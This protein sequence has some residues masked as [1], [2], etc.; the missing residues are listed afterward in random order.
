M[1]TK[2]ITQI[3]GRFMKKFYFVLLFIMAISFAGNAQTE[4]TEKTANDQPI[5]N[6]VEYFMGIN[7]GIDFNTNA[8]PLFKNGNYGYTYFGVSP[9]YNIGADFAVKITARLRPRLEFKYVNVKYGVDWSTLQYTFGEST[10]VNLNYFDIN[11]HLDYLLLSVRKFQLFVSPAFKFEAQTGYSLSTSKLYLELKQPSSIA[12]GG[13][14]A[15]FKYK[16]TKHI[17]FTLTPDYTIFA[18]SFV[19]GN[20]KPY[21]R[22]SANFGVEFKFGE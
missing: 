11:L 10:I 2:A 9:S 21:Q 5:V 15:I 14:S 12:G 16:M 20:N 17:G 19:L 6:E 22:F 7:G 3:K 1:K 18:H 13:L 4:K 8:Y